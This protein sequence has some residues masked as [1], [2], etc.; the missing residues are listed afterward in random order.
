MSP[1]CRK[2]VPSIDTLI[3]M[4]TTVDKSADRR[5]RGAGLAILKPF[6]IGS[7]PNL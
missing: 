4:P 5:V 3:V 1:K 6:K 7:G 2:S